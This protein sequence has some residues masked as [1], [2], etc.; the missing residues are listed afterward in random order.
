MESLQLRMCCGLKERGTISLFICSKIAL[1]QRIHNFLCNM[2][3]SNLNSHMELI[4]HDKNNVLISL[5]IIGKDSST[6]SKA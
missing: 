6:L 2:V 4:R 5:Q 3:F 1:F